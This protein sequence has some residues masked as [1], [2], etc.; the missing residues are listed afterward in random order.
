MH[1]SQGEERPGRWPGNRVPKEEPEEG[2]QEQTPA[3][4][5][6]DRPRLRGVRGEPGRAWAA[7][8]PGTSHPIV[9]GL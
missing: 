9:D 2:L 4:Q 5:G 1:Q 7:V 3:P 6:G 8:P